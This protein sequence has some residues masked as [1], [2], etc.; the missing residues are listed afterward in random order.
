MLI[1]AREARGF[2]QEELAARMDISQG[3]LSKIENGILEDI[4][5][6]LP[7]I[8]ETLHFPETFFFQEERRFEIGTHFY[9]KRLSIPKKELAQ[10]KAIIDILKINIDKLLLSI[11]VP[12]ENLPKW[13]V[14]ED[15]EP[16]LYANFLREKWRIPRGR[17][18]NL[19]TII[20]NNGIVV[21][22]VDFGDIK[23]D[24]L[25]IYTKTNQAIIF[26]NK[27]LPGDRI[28]FTLAH[29]LGHLGMHFSQKVSLDRDVE[30]EAMEFASELLIPTKE[31]LPYL[32]KLNLDKLAE[33]KRYWRVSM[34]AILFKAK[35]LNLVKDNTYRY[36]WTQFRALNYN[37]QEPLSIDIPVEKPSLV[38]EIIDAFLNDLNY[39]KSDLAKLLSLDLSDLEDF[40]FESRIKFK[41]IKM[42]Q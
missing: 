31:I 28:R 40:Y 20:E 4:N 7:K 35:V 21:I 9:R 30:K 12:E 17:I 2:S 6:Y 39:S 42:N 1:L 15:G 37:N 34:Q 19:T 36:L 29:E 3:T 18:D 24:G 8:C 23:L 38:K 10:A 11:D 32:T 33:L 27:L 41:V 14:N 5:E 13:D 26:L 16:S 22:H 25:S